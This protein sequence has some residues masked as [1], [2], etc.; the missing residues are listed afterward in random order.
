[1][2]RKKDSF[3]PHHWKTGSMIG[4]QSPAVPGKWQWAN[5]KHKATWFKLS[6]NWLHLWKTCETYWNITEGRNCLSIKLRLCIS[7][8]CRQQWCFHVTSR[9]PCRC[10]STKERRPCWCPQLI[11]QELNS[12]L[13]RMFSSVL[14]EKH[15]HWSREWKHSI[16]YDCSQLFYTLIDC[17]RHSISF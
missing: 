2:E 6:F 13:M 15:A 9:R 7:Y 5:F 10:P 12:I 3:F 1:M 16:C 14:V 8:W 11:L 17:I 4:D